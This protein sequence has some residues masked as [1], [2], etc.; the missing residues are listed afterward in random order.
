MLTSI[1]DELE[2]LLGT[3]HH[4]LSTSHERDIAGSK[5][6]DSFNVD[7]ILNSGRSRADQQGGSC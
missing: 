4:V 7:G 6:D 2:A 5:Q 3:C 1:T